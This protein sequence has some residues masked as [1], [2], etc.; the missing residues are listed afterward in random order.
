M[1]DLG[2]Y[3]WVAWLGLAI[4]LGAVEVTTLDLTFL[5]L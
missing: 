5:M 1:G 3:D 4:V 2:G